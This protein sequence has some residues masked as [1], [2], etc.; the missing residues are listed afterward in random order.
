MIITQDV[1]PPIKESDPSV[2]ELI[3]TEEVVIGTEQ[4]TT[5]SLQE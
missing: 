4:G 3:H 1:D 2:Q 5:I